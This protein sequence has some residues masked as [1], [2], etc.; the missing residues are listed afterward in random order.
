MIQRFI[1]LCLI[2]DL[3]S[4]FTCSDGSLCE[5]SKTCC[6]RTDGTYGCCPLRGAVCC[7]DMLHCCPENTICDI[8]HSKCIGLT[9]VPWVEKIPATHTK[10]SLQEETGS[11]PLVQAGTVNALTENVCLDNTEC[12]PE[13][14][15]MPTSKGVYGCCPLTAATICKDLEHCCPKGYECDLVKLTCKKAGNEEELP[16]ISGIGN[17]RSAESELCGN[18]SCSEG[19]TCCSSKDFGWGC[20]PMKDAVCCG[21][22]CCPKNFQCN[23]ARKTCFKPIDEN[24][25]AVICPDGVS[26]CP[27]GSTCCLVSEEQWGCCPIEKAVCCLDHLHCCPANTKCDLKQSKCM[28]EYGMMEMWKKFPAYRRFTVK[29]TKVHVVR[30][31]D[32]VACQDNQTCCLLVSGEYGCCPLPHAVCCPDHEHCCPEGWICDSTGKCFFG[33]ISIPWITKTPA[34]VQGSMTDVK[35]NDTVAC[36]KG[37]TCCKRPSGDWECCPLPEAV[38]C[39]DHE[40]CCPKG[41]TC[42]L[43]SMICEKKNVCVP[44]KIKQLPFSDIECDDMVKCP[45]SA[46][47]CKV[48]SGSWSCCPYSQATCCEDMMHCCPNGYT[49]NEGAKACTLKSQLHWGQLFLKRKKV[50]NTL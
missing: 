17:M 19:Y 9:S 49:C 34:I 24:V 25:K 28:S 20:C 48:A 16:L 37:D 43:V 42:N 15:C 40:H 50:F 13:Y 29:N 33:D 45:S 36:L 18:M 14:T 30:C 12:P 32:T 26:E 31:N 11:I 8:A 41:Y 23:K 3:A 39:Q 7:S 21:D 46:T 27:E 10:T 4:V 5:D 1:I 22:R 38:C 44:R 6:K 2:S 35:C 47:C